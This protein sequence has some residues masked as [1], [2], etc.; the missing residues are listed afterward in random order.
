MWQSSESFCVMV[1]YFFLPRIAHINRK[2]QKELWGK[3]EGKY[4]PF[5]L[6]VTFR[7]TLIALI[8][9]INIPSPTTIA[10]LHTHATTSD[11]KIIHTFDAAFLEAY[12]ATLQDTVSVGL[13]IGLLQKL[14]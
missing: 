9:N 4:I 13:S 6:S 5:V 10:T 11:C 1:T 12:Y 2:K 7:P 3:S 14:L 8:C